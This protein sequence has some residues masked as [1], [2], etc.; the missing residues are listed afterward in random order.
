MSISLFKKGIPGAG[1]DAF[2]CPLKFRSAKEAGCAFGLIPQDGLIFYAPLSEYAETAVTGQWLETSGDIEYTEEN[3]VPCGYFDGE[4][5]LYYDYGD[6]D[7]PQGAEPNTMSVWAKATHIE[8][9]VTPFAYGYG[10]TEDD[11]HR[12]ICLMSDG[13]LEFSN[14]DSGV[15]SSGVPVDYTL[16][17]HYCLT[18]SDVSEGGISLY[19]DGIKFKT[20]SC[21]LNTDS[22]GKLCIGVDPWKPGN[23]GLMYGYLASCRIYDRVLSLSEIKALAREFNV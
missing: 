21:R 16:W 20:G 5:Y 3:G 4:S 7:L 18:I 17:H 10:F 6:G 1:F 19:I 8:D 14:N 15:I 23:F 12:K 11:N 9:F 2:G 22:E 13:T